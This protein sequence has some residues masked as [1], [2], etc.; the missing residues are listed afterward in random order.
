MDKNNINDDINILDLI[1]TIWS[2]KLTVLS[3]IILALVIA[4][5][6]QI[7]QKPSKIIAITKINPISIYD[8]VKYQINNSFI[9]EINFYDK[10]SSYLPGENFINNYNKTELFIRD[11]RSSSSKIEKKIKQ[12]FYINNV[13]AEFLYNLFV[14]KL[15][16]KNTLI[17]LIKKYNLIQKENYPDNQKYEEKVFELA[18]AIKITKGISVIIQYEGYEIVNWENFLKFADEEI[19]LEIQKKLSEMFIGYIK[20]VE[21][22]RKFEIEDTDLGISNA[23]S[24]DQIVYLERKKDMII[25][26]KYTER[27]KKLFSDSPIS[28]PDEFY[29][30]RIVYN[31]TNYEDIIKRFSIKKT[32]VIAGLIGAVFGMIFVLMANAIQNHKIKIVSRR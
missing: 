28:K 22:I 1:I 31:S 2:K 3:F 15:S 27:V 12:V 25:Q 26:N 14:E 24:G 5:P 4:I 18:S 9:E 23:L 7:T 19:N 10:D 32:I 8:E 16:Q 29:A 20:Y 13:S 11:D 6:F 21:T 17:S 30:A